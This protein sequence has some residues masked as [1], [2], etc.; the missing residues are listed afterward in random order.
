MPD[1]S[2]GLLG[3]PARPGKPREVGLT[4][5]MDKGLNLRDIEG[6]FDTAGAVRRHRQ[7][8]LGHELRHE[9]PREED[10][11]L[12]ARSRRP[13]SAAAR[14]S[15]RSTRAASSTSS[16]AWLVEHRFAH[17]EISDGTI[18]I[19]RE[20]EARADRGLRARLHGALG[21]RLE[22]LGR[23][24]RAL[25]VG[26]VDQGGARGGRLEGDHRGAARAARP[27]SSARTATCAPG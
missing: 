3:V 21:G 18:E 23:R 15:R 19:P 8:R 13:S 4:H 11:A 9:Q 25:P 24:L 22:G 10:R 2:D 6:L 7:A 12:P 20:R 27:G 26:R 17:V 16:S 5:V 1:F 14:C